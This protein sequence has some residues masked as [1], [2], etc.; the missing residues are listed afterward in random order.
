VRR[1]GLRELVG[2]MA[3]MVFGEP[4]GADPGENLGREDA[5]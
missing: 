5:T 2:R 3:G 4:D 1:E